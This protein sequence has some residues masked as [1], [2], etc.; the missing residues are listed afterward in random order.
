VTICKTPGG[1]PALWIR[2]PTARVPNGDFSDGF[3]MIVLPVAS[4]GAAFQAR[5]R[6]DAFHA[7]IPAQTPIGSCSTIL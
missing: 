6:S 1:K 7:V 4:A 5:N 2:Y 3:I